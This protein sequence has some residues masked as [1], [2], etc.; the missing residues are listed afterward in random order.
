M[1]VS[2]LDVV[3]DRRQVS[4]AAGGVNVAV[5]FGTLAHEAQAGTEQVAQAPPLFGIS[6]GEGEVAAAQQPGNG[7]SVVTVALGL[8]AMHGFHGPGVAEGE[9][10]VGVAASVSEPVP[11]VHA[12]A[13]DDQAFAEGLHGAEE[14]F[15][16]GRQ[17]T[18]E[19]GGAFAV[20]D[21]EEEGPGVEID[22][23][24]ESGVGGRLEVTHGE[25]LRV[26]VRR[27]EAAGCLLH[28]RRREPS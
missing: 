22:A 28:L 23:G 16:G 15:G 6:V 7:F 20:E 27:R 24:I 17:V 11:A 18:A 10:D 19:A 13:A 26:R 25:G 14:G 1:V 21:A 4:L 9:D 8:A 5:E 3:G 2:V 12:L